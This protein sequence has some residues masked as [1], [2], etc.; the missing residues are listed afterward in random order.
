MEVEKEEEEGVY[1]GK[2]QR[3]VVA[4][5]AALLEEGFHKKGLLFASPYR[6]FNFFSF[7]T[8]LGR[9]ARNGAVH[10]PVYSWTG[11]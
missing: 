1:Q 10:I 2:R 4:M 5:A 3:I 6:C 7:K 9:A 11:T 8:E